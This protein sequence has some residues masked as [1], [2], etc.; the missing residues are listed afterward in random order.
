MDPADT[1]I[2]KHVTATFGFEVPNS[3]AVP[4]LRG[5]ALQ[6]RILNRLERLLARTSF[7]EIA[8]LTT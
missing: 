6:Q 4:Q 2:D 7:R 3:A 1:C 8:K 5:S